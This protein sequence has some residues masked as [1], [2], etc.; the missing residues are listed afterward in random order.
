MELLGAR[1]GGNGVRAV[2]AGEDDTK[3]FCIC[4]ILFG[5]GLAINAGQR[6]GWEG[7]TDFDDFRNFGC[8]RCSC[9]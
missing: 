5:V 1:G 3:N 7:G 6:E 4:K 2:V 9:K 8:H